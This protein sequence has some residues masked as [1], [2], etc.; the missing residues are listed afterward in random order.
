MKVLNFYLLLIFC[1]ALL[2]CRQ[3][4]SE[5]KEEKAPQL[6]KKFDLVVK[7][8]GLRL[9]RQAG[10]EGEMIR[11]LPQG[12]QLKDLR[13]TSDFTSRIQLGKQ[14]YDEPW[15]KVQTE[16][17]EEGWL[18]ARNTAFQFPSGQSP[19]TWQLEKRL[20]AYFGSAK[21]ETLSGFR[22][23]FER[24]ASAEDFARVYQEGIDLR[25]E[26]VKILEN[27]TSRLAIEELPDL[28]WLEEAIPAFTP[29]VVAEG[30]A[31]YLFVNYKQWLKKA[32]QTKSDE[33]DAFINMCISFFPQDSIEYFF[34]N[35]QIQTWDYGGHSM[36]G[37]GRHLAA[38]QKIDSLHQKGAI[39]QALSQKWLRLILDDLIKPD[40][41]FWEPLESAGRELNQIITAN[42]KCLSQD[43][44]IALTV[45]RK[46]FENIEKYGLEFNHK[47]G[48][49]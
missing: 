19:K 31:Y 26:F 36:L 34:P 33:D 32:K 1:V 8:E 48:L 49:Y 45:R 46:Q 20:T 38:L 4:E 37:R 16:T 15:I 47:S 24:I 35:W 30:T 10:V 23:A 25:E 41:T 5:L 18:Y 7:E 17:G 12:A 22:I 44:K 39:F 42:F 28:F 11:A 40:V 9:W 27:K 14:V 6:E 43:D 29:Q 21:V 2:G 3:Q 13:Q